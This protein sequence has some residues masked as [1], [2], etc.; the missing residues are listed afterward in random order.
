[1]NKI[2]VENASQTANIANQKLLADKNYLF[3]LNGMSVISVTGDRAAEFLQG[4]LSCDV[5]DVNETTMRKGAQCNLKGR[6]LTLLNVINW[7]GLQL[8]LPE[9]LIDVTLTSLTKTAFVSRV[10]L[11]PNQ[12]IKVYGFYLENPLD[13]LPFNQPLPEGSCSITS[14]MDSCIYSISD[15]MYLILARSDSAQTLMEPFRVHQQIASSLKWHELQLQQLQVQIYPQTR[16]LF[17]PHRIDLHKSGFISFDKG[18]YKGQ[19]IIA[20]T[21]YRAKLK[22]GLCKFIIETREALSVGMKIFNT[23]DNSETGE[24]IDFCPI[25]GGNYLI[26]TSILMEHPEYVLFESHMEPVKLVEVSA[27]P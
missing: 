14:T 5:R 22:H 27:A 21:H 12:D 17:L 25:E 8:V 15:H 24:L 10:N 2:N 20:R 9:S 4:Q 23:I 16:G 18:C 19:E 3:E 11:H 13:L 1:M 26:V 6:V 7:H